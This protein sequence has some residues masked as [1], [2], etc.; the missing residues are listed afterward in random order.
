MT[1]PSIT[2]LQEQSAAM[3]SGQWEVDI[4]GNDQANIYSGDQWIAILPNRSITANE[5]NHALDAAG[6]CALHAATSVLLEIAAAALEYR[7]TMT[8][9]ESF[10]SRCEALDQALAKVRP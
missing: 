4:D 7:K 10:T 3:T 8:H 5:A 6:I 9:A 2:E 1:K